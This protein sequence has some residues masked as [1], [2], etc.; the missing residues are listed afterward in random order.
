[1]L[2]A[3]HCEQGNHLIQP[4]HELTPQVEV[5]RVHEEEMMMYWMS[6]L[7][8]IEGQFNESVNLVVD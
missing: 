2:H 6:L 1:M 5:M 4:S 3:Q 8:E 7:H